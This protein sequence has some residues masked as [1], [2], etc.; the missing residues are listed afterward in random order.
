MKKLLALFAAVVFSCA[1][2]SVVET[3]TL[4]P[5][6]AE[7]INDYCNG[8]TMAHAQTDNPANANFT[9]G[10]TVPDNSESGTVW[11]N[12]ILATVQQSS[13]REQWLKGWLADSPQRDVALNPSLNTS[14]RFSPDGGVPSSWQQ[15]SVADAG[16]LVFPIGPLPAGRK[17][18]SCTARIKNPNTTNVSIG[19]K[20]QLWLSAIDVSGTSGSTVAIGNVSDTTAVLATYQAYHSVTIGSL[21]HVINANYTYGVQF[22]GETG[23]NSTTGLVLGRIYLTL[24]F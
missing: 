18:L 11:W 22:F 16:N 19:T 21:S 7:C 3:G 23:T 17:I 13:D 24:G 8:P 12:L 1:P 15:I 10:K 9:V 4:P 20:P 2:E 14:S 5:T 6:I